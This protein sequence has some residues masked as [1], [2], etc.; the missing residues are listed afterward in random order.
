M[1]DLN[2]FEI[3]VLEMVDGKRPQEWGAWVAVCLEHL[4]H[5][6]FIT[7]YVG[8]KPELTA[9]GRAALKEAVNG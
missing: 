1:A 2:R 7:E 3:E 8:A 4:K 5:H 6:G 9:S